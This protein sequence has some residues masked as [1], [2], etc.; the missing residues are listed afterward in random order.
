MR[1]A[2]F[3]VKRVFFALVTVFVAITLNFILFRTLSGDAVSALRC[4]QCTAQFKD[5]KTCDV[6][7]GDME[8]CTKAQAKDFCNPGDTCDAVAK[9]LLDCDAQSH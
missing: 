4:R 6:T 8:A 7:V 3:V 5:A 9:K 2:D 1:G